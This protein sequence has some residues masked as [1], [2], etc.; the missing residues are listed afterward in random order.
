MGENVKGAVWTVDEIEFQKRRP[1]KLSGPAPRPPLGMGTG[2]PL[3][4]S[5]FNAAQALQQHQNVMQQ[6][7]VNQG[8]QA[9]QA[10]QQQQQQ[11]QQ[12]NQMAQA[13]FD[14]SFGL[15]NEI[16]QQSNT[17][18]LP[19]MLGKS[20]SMISPES[21]ESEMNDNN[22][23]N[24]QKQLWQL[25]KSNAENLLKQLTAN[26]SNLN[27]LSSIQNTLATLQQQQQQSKPVD[28][29]TQN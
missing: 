10:H 21:K 23:N 19:T 3:G 16:D 20:D 14:Q 12:A 2:F 9:V 17:S 8:L 11:Q 6:Q 15:E 28:N 27:S 26:N 29:S 7:M 4:F 24:I 5:N 18:G 25:Q 13:Q 22:A 1:Q